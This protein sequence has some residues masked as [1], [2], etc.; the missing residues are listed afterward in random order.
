MGFSR[1]VCG[2]N[3]VDW[4]IANTVVQLQCEGTTRIRSVVDSGLVGLGQSGSDNRLKEFNR[5]FYSQPIGPE[6]Q[7]MK[8]FD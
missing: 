6:F 1:S 3:F 4:D 7:L 2:T 8:T 5:C